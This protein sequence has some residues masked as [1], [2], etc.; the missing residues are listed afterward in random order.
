MPSP[1][2][3]PFDLS[4]DP[5]G[6]LVLRREG[7]DDVVDVRV[8][9][10]FP[11]SE[12]GRHVSVRSAEG[13]EVLL[14]EDLA[15]LPAALRQAIESNLSATNFIPRITR[16]H[17]LDTS[18]GHQQWT[19]ETDRGPAAFRVQEREDVRFM[20]GGRFRIKDADGNLYELPPLDQLDDRSRKAVEPLL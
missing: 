9:R 11:W 13:K 7:Q 4:T 6:R 16:V 15:A 3:H 2:A 18:F 8:R 19:V 5:Q 17:D 10:A 12:P 20:D 1:T 14:I